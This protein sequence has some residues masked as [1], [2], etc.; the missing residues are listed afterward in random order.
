M[1]VSFQSPFTKKDEI[2]DKKWKKV[3]GQGK[4]YR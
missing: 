3:K 1:F 4:N 2:I